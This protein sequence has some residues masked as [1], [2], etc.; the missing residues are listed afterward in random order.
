MKLTARQQKFVHAYIAS[1]NASDAAR[2]A[3]Y[4]KPGQEGYRLLK[5]AQVARAIAQVTAAGASAKIADAQER[6]EFWTAVMRG[7]HDSEMK[8]RL[9]A[10]ELLGKTAGDFTETRRVVVEGL[11]WRA[12]IADPRGTEPDA[13]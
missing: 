6:K 11:D 1:G 8:D 5:N 3:G 2:R 12:L 7:D 4:G 9:K 13:A 10:A